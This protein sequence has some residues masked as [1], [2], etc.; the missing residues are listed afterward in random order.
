MCDILIPDS[1]YINFK[2]CGKP[3]KNYSH[4][5]ETH[6]NWRNE[7]TRHSE[8]IGKIMRYAFKIYNKAIEFAFK[9]K[10]DELEK[11]L[12]ENPTNESDIHDIIAMIAIRSR[13]EKMLNLTNHHQR[14]IMEDCASDE[15]LFPFLIECYA[16][17]NGNSRYDGC[18][19]IPS[20]VW[21]ACTLKNAI[22]LHKITGENPELDEC[23]LEVQEHFGY[24]EIYT[25]Y[26]EC[27]EHKSELDANKEPPT[28]FS[29]P[30]M[31]VY[32]PPRFKEQQSN[33][34]ESPKHIIQI[35][36]A[37]LCEELKH[38]LTCRPSLFIQKRNGPKISIDKYITYKIYFEDVE[39]SSILDLKKLDKKCVEKITMLEN[40][41]YTYE[42][43]HDEICECDIRCDDHVESILE[44]LDDNSKFKEGESGFSIK[45]KDYPISII[46]TYDL[47]LFS[48]MNDDKPNNIVNN[49]VAQPITSQPITSQPVVA[50]PTTI[51]P[52]INMHNI[53]DQ[54]FANMPAI[55][56]QPVVN[57][58]MMVEEEKY[59]VI[60]DRNIEKE[61]ARL[62]GLFQTMDIGSTVKSAYVLYT[63]NDDS[64]TPMFEFRFMTEAERNNIK[65]IRWTHRGHSPCKFNKCLIDCT[66][67]NGSKTIPC[68]CG[69]GRELVQYTFWKYDITEDDNKDDSDEEENNKKHPDF[70]SDEEWRD[71]FW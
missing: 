30:P 14:K 11:I 58:P 47:N 50:Q 56:G 42:D 12:N 69:W 44:Y 49:N 46:F 33:S 59:D 21:N 65:N 27:P 60:M 2:R 64:I 66:Y 40:G 23:N 29:L 13:D 19:D 55:M 53:I 63:I 39:Y 3:V 61:V 62:I 36:H 32:E 26:M 71:I 35:M 45:C 9:R 57:I 34:N 37:F 20:Y 52:N 6:D 41:E 54:Y 68:H 5:C 18:W 10:Y 43:P 38:C 1:D 51:Q 22:M 31:Y 4:K 24:D 15:E 28:I 17:N 8:S 48:A 70:S 7:E 25:L 16:R 67:C